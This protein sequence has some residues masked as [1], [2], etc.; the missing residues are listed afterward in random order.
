MD[1]FLKF[2][3][4]D[5]RPL[6]TVA[7]ERLDGASVVLVSGEPWTPGHTYRIERVERAFRRLGFATTT[8]PVDA[9]ATLG[10]SRWPAILF[11]WRTYLTPDLDRR[12]QDAHRAGVRI[13][14]D[15]DDLMVQPDLAIA[16]VIDGIRSQGLS[17]NAVREHYEGVRR[18]AD[19]AHILTTPTRRLTRHLRLG[20]RRGVTLP[21]TFDE[22]TLMTANLAAR[23]RRAMPS[24]GLFRI[25]YATGSKTHQRDL[26]VAADGIARFMKE[27]PTARLVLFKETIDLVEL[28]AL[29]A[30]A[31]QIEWRDVVALIHLPFELSRLDVNLAPL[32]TGNP[33]CESK[34]QLKYFEA[35]LVDVPTV[36][37]PTEPY[38][39][40]IDD[41]V[42][43]LLA[44]S[45]EQWTAALDFLF[46]SS[47]DRAAIARAAKDAALVEFGPERLARDLR[48]VIAEALD[49]SR[50]L[51]S[52]AALQ[53]RRRRLRSE[54]RQRSVRE[55]H[56]L[57]D[58]DRRRPVRVSVIVPL[59]NYAHYVTEALSSVLAQ[60]SD[61][62][63]LIVIDDASTD[64]SHEVATEW[65]RWNGDR[66]ARARVV[67]LGTNAGLGAA[68]NL[69]F[70]L[71]TAP[72]VL[73]LDAD[74]L[75]L[76][77]CVADL[78]AALDATDASFAYSHIRCFGQSGLVPE[79]LLGTQN[80]SPAQLAGGNYIDAMAMIRKSAWLTA[81]GYRE[82][83]RSGW[84]DYE[85]WCRFVEHDLYGTRVPKV[86]CEYRIHTDSMI[87][88]RTRS[89]VI[90]DAV[91]TIE[92]WHPW[93]GHPAAMM[94]RD[95]LPPAAVDE[96][97]PKDHSSP[98]Q[99][100]PS[101]Q[102]PTAQVVEP[103]PQGLS[104]RA[105]R[106]LPILRCPETGER[107]QEHDD[108][109]VAET[110]GRVWPI[111]A[112]RPVL[113]PGMPRAQV[114][115]ED[116]HSNPLPLSAREL[117]TLATGWVLNLG[118]GATSVD[119]DNVVNAEAAIFSNTDAVADAHH[120]PFADGSFDCVVSLNVF[121]HFAEPHRAADELFRVLRPG[122]QLL[123]Q[124][125]FLQPLHEGPWHFF[126]A[127]KYGV[128]QWFR[129][130]ADVDVTVTDNFHPGFTLGWIV[131]EA[132]SLV[133]LHGSETDRS[134]LRATTSAEL[135]GLWTDPRTRSGPTWEALRKLPSA[136]KERIAA[137]FEVRAVKPLASH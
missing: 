41:R 17:E 75:L 31:N 54:R 92:E 77:D 46:Q 118:A 136:A 132:I 6:G 69:G 47:D 96:P 74:N 21:N 55:H 34:S 8:M 16:A 97:T 22:S 68:R 129:E 51:T 20:G 30:V 24:D 28:P 137:G 56:V 64:E 89:G 94:V 25:G 122:G 44:G 103:L 11:L 10:P 67:R 19:L 1:H 48:V 86:L 123:V 29:M 59:Y 62:I 100:A 61:E 133:D 32:E 128:S 60:T 85:L 5:G 15:I 52:E 134:T 78:A 131:A 80:F 91:R 108:H 9:F 121:E 104:E 58:V 109:L 102:T 50:N 114:M 95:T 57:I 113:F 112:G 7:D 76:P 110:S 27:H 105:R 98:V 117:M 111:V 70:E 4:A 87:H 35:A 115:P 127:T 124:T 120:L 106:V 93:V 23:H 43:G 81:G 53:V 13:V 33:Y 135:A 45:P 65:V 119:N 71:A 66:L 26:A 99:L 88:E 42:N 37:S 36:A 79:G 101:V 12:L 90:D 73:P 116:H 2:G 125:A 130:F 3:F 82:D 49:D 40:A 72:F 18:S 107:L 39:D 14:F 38:A 83:W 126:N 84:E 63:E